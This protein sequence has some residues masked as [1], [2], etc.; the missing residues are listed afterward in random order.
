MSLAGDPSVADLASRVLAAVARYVPHDFACLAV[1]DPASGVVTWAAKTRS[2]GVGDEEFAAVESGPP[3]VN[4]FADLARRV[5]PVGALGIDTGGHPERSRRHRDL[6]LPRFGF[7]D[8]LRAVFPA[9]GVVWGALALYRAGN[10][11]AFSRTDV[12][13]LA[14][15]TGLVGTALARS[16]FRP[17]GPVDRATGDGATGTVPAVFVV[18]A[19]DRVVQLTASAESAVADLGGWDSGSLPASL[20][21]VVAAARAGSGSAQTVAPTVGGRWLRLRA[22]RL[23]GPAGTADVVVTVDPT[24]RQQ[25]SRLALAAHGLTLREEEV[26]LLVLQGASTQAI[27][28]ALHLSPHTVQDHLKKIFGK[29]GVT[30]RRD[31]TARLTVG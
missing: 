23:T 7:T 20:L 18:D 6:M 9:R 24:P 11:P 30:S 1:T 19:A 17:A 12:D 28:A 22:A 14:A 2:L 27:A 13:E 25:L 16:L 31:L 3:D 26:A 5:P 4:S 21:M 8:E 29:V 15:V 10:D